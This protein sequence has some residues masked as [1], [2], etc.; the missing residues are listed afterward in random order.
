MQGPRRMLFKGSLATLCLLIAS[1]PQPHKQAWKA[2]LRQ[3]GCHDK[4]HRRLASESA[5]P[6]CD[7]G[8]PRPIVRRKR[9]E[10]RVVSPQSNALSQVGEAEWFGCLARE[11]GTQTISGMSAHDRCSEGAHAHVCYSRV[12]DGRGRVANRVDLLVGD[13]TQKGIDE[14]LVALI[15]SQASIPCQR[16]YHKA[17]RPDAQ[18]AGELA[19]PVEHHP[20]PAHGPPIALLDGP[21]PPAPPP[22]PENA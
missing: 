6:A 15:D 20:V 10:D 22:S 1:L 11:H 7:V 2:P 9:E 18:V 8:R 14:H 12:L 3:R 13:R 4:V 19:P 21:P 5:Q 17:P 16:R